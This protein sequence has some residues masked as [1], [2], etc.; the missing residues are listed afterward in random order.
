MIWREAFD[1]PCTVQA[2]HSGASLHAH[3]HLDGGYEVEPG[4]KV[5]VLGPPIMLRFGE[6][7]T[8][9]RTA[10]VSRANL[11]ERLLTKIMGHFEMAELY[12]VSF[13][14]GRAR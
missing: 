13:T 4:D 7:L 10:R 6:T 14:P 5:R 8:L 2:E 12:E 11:I 9:R 1:T 3:V